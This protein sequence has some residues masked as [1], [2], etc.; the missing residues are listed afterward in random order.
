M[1]IEGRL[2]TTEENYLDPVTYVP[3]HV[4]GNASHKDCKQGVIIRVEENGIFVLYCR[5]RTTQ[6][7]ASVSLV[8]G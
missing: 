8:W 5:S 4:N 7:T 3:F 2:V 6:I 1:E